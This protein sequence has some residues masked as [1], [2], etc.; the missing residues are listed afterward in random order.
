MSKMWDNEL[1]SGTLKH[2]FRKH[3]RIFRH[4][5][6]EEED[7]WDLNPHDPDKVKKR[8][9]PTIRMVYS[10]VLKKHKVDVM[11]NKEILLDL[12]IYIRT[13][14]KDLYDEHMLQYK[15]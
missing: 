12:V 15:K 13:E 4:G 2:I 10:W 3:V 5:E 11:T 9:V 1:M 14:H 8:V 7:T 6:E